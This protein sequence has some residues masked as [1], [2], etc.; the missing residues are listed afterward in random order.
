[1]ENQI[2]GACSV[3]GHESYSKQIAGLP[4]QVGT[5]KDQTIQR[6]RREENLDEES[7]YTERFQLLAIVT[8]PRISL[9][10]LLQHQTHIL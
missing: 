1:M 10:Q 3:M 6:G 5:E 8:N 4:L 9:V 7:T 2:A